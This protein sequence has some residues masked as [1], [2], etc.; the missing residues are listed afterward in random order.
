MNLQAFF[1]TPGKG[2]GCISAL[3]SLA[4]SAGALGQES[5][6]NYQG[7]LQNNSSPANGVYDLRFELFDAA[8]AGTSLG[9]QNKP[10]VPVTNGLFSSTLDYGT[11][12]FTGGAR[13]LEVS[14]SPQGANTYTALSPRH[15]LT[16]TP[17]AIRAASVPAVGVIGTLSSSA[18]SGAYSS[19]VN[20]SNAGNVFA[21]NGSSLTNVT[22]IA[23]TPEAANTYWRIGGNAGVAA[24][25]YIGTTDYN[26]IELRVNNSPGVRLLPTTQNWPNLIN[27]AANNYILSDV[28]GTTIGGGVGNGVGNVSGASF[29]GSG[30]TNVIGDNSAGSVIGG[31]TGNVFGDGS[32]RSVISG[33]WSNFVGGDTRPSAASLA[34]DITDGTSNTVFIDE[35][36]PGNSSIGG[37]W[38]NRIGQNAPSCSISGGNFNR[39]NDGTSNILPFLE[40]EPGGCFIGGGRGNRIGTNQPSNVIV[41]GDKNFLAGDGTVRFIGGG[42]SNSIADG[43]SHTAIIGGGQNVIGAS[44]AYSVIGGGNGNS[45]GAAASVIVGGKANII[46]TVSGSACIVGGA[47]NTVGT[48]SAGSFVGGGTNNVFADGSV[49]SVISGGWQNYVGGDARPVATGF[50]QDITDGTSNTILVNE[51][52]PGNCFIGGGWSNRIGTTAPSCTIAGGTSNRIGDATVLLPFIEAAPAQPGDSFVGGGRGNRIGTTYPANVIC[53]GDR[54]VLLGDGAVRF[55]GGGRLNSIT[56]GTSNTIIAG[57]SNAI[58]TGSSYSLIGGGVGNEITGGYGVISGGF[59]NIT[60]AAHAVIGGGKDNTASGATSAIHGGSGNSANGEL[61]AVSGGEFNS[62]FGAKSFVGGGAGN[63]ATGESS[64]VGGGVSNQASGQYSTIPGGD[65]NSAAQRAFAAGT[66]AKAV[67]TGAFVWA[68]STAADFSSTAGNQFIVRASGGVGIGKNNPTQALDVVGNIVATG[69]I[70]GSSDRN[71][72]E[73]FTPVNPRD[74]LD[75]VAALPIQRW[76]YIGDEKAPHIGPVAQDFHAAFAVGMDDKHISMVDADGIALAAI[77]GLNEKLQAELDRRDAEKAQL[78]KQN[79]ELAARLDVLEQL[80]KSLASE[81]ARERE[82]APPDK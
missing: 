56:D 19:A 51:I 44:S 75:K 80:V 9:V 31:G 16:A 38:A 7:R 74:V 35:I 14:V 36:P 79:D 71:V 52:A 50:A 3:C 42:R 48:K 59:N 1:H 18:L 25:R 70:T 32:V 55:I 20:F 8:A 26:P 22:A 60:S 33:G 63:Q 15:R 10:S 73:N 57:E 37:G 30:R 21:G 61:A 28:T 12:P 72:K 77:Q 6:F 27:G 45:A 76:N 40:S 34:R 64:T 46:S 65:S 67:H 5:A 47:A 69:T 4:L 17:Y 54:N 29:V 49:R 82:N 53:G 58:N 24:N 41:G 43:S 2:M 68:D 81:K 78:K 11:A 66:R 23:L 62:A 13:W 39:I